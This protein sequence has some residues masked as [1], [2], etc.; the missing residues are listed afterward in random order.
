MNQ[1]DQDKH[2]IVSKRLNILFLLVFI[3]LTVLIFRLSFV[4]LTL[5]DV[6]T[7]KADQNSYI[8]QNIPA[9]RG[10]IKD[11]N[12]D[13]IVRN[14]PAFTITFQRLDDD[15]QDPMQ[16]IGILS[17]KLNIPP[18]ELYKKMDP[19][20]EPYTRK[21]VTNAKSDIVAYV[22]EHS[23]ELPGIN[24]VV[25]PIRQY[26]YGNLASHVL[27]YLNDI[28]E[29]YWKDHQDTYKKSDLIGTSGIEKEYEKYLKGK[30]GELR[31]EVNRNYQPLNDKR[32]LDPVP[33][34]NLYL[35]IDRHIQEATEK[36]LAAKVQEMHKTIETVKH[37]AAIAMN[38]KTGEILA[39]ASYPSYNPNDWVDGIS[40]EE[41]QRFAPAEMNRAIQ[42]VYEP[43]STIKMS[44][45]LIGLKEGAI[46]PYTFFHDPGITYVGGQPIRSWKSIGTIDPYR[47]IAESSN[48]Y[49]IET[50]RRVFH[51][52]NVQ[53]VNYFNTVTQPAMMQKVLAYHEEF[54]LGLIKTG[55]DLPY[56]EPGQITLE[57]QFTDFAFASF[58]QIEKYTLLQLAN[59]V[60]TIANDGKRMQPYV[61]S[62]IESPN[63]ETIEEHK[64]KLLNK[65]SFT[66]EQ[67]DV[68]QQGMRD[69]ITKPYG[70][71][72]W[73][74]GN[75]P[76][77]IAGKTGTSE[78]GRGTE[79]SLFVGYAPYD[80]PEVAIA[81]IIPDNEHESH[82][83]T[84]LGPIAKAM[85][86][87]YF[88]LDQKPAADAK[89]ASTNP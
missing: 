82:S 86:D 1:Q 72:N 73:V 27:G 26:V 71:F 47:A 35:T 13:I 28:P 45:I 39:M 64:P 31:V 17:E 41:Y 85:F 79:N 48:V 30:D 21:I 11:R 29:D 4:Q 50:F 78:T 18:Y 40:N 43:G 62:K 66:Q 20:G 12:E 15:R 37:G 89:A 44:T 57:N 33:G 75:Y 6:Y 74:M 24:V 77:P 70:T 63:G 61:V 84:T 22:R 36:A 81:I 14:S 67:L 16:L 38:P 32:T 88:K 55:I 52:T 8:K 3:T 2:S 60:S 87:A 19:D 49:M 7:K 51:A 46:T 80:N 5:G 42:Q 68:V 58:G 54:G 59:Y 76:Y 23:Y 53:D 56:E 65:V 10:I 9:P 25:E 83:G 69:T 34:D